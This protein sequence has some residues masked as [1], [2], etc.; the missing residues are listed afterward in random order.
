MDAIKQFDEDDDS[1]SEVPGII[2]D[3]EQPQQEEPQ[4]PKGTT[5][6]ISVSGTDLLFKMDNRTIKKIALKSLK[7]LKLSNP[8]HFR[9]IVSEFRTNGADAAI[10]KFKI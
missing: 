4:G 10:K 3:T 8:D 1:V 6:G 5:Y 7:G 2:E 9:G